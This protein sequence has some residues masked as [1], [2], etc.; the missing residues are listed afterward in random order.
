MHEIDYLNDWQIDDAKFETMMQTH[1]QDF[2]AY[3]GE[4]DA[5]MRSKLG[6]K[7]IHL[8]F[9]PEL[10]FRADKKDEARN[11]AKYFRIVGDKLLYARKLK[12]AYDYLLKA[13]T[14][15]KKLGESRV[16]IFR[17]LA[18][19]C[20]LVSLKLYYGGSA[21]SNWKWRAELYAKAE[22]RD[23][24]NAKNPPKH[25]RELQ[26]E[27][28]DTEEY[29]LKSHKADNAIRYERLALMYLIMG[30]ESRCE[31][32]LGHIADGCFCLSCRY[33]E[34]YDRLIVLGYMAEFHGDRAKAAEYFGRAKA[35]APH[36]IE[37]TMSYLANSR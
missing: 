19:C 1:P 37:N 8:H 36:D 33:Q 2:D 10:W 6:V 9:I 7:F 23:C 34:C 18:I 26:G 15:R 21:G 14:I 28:M 25:I 5:K 20:K 13:C 31:E 3:F 24:I 35:I 11:V 29:Y 12:K 17:S 4:F 30:D 27:P 22:I 16:G 32:Y